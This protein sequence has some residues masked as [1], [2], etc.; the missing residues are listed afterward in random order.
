VKGIWLAPAQSSSINLN[1][2]ALQVHGFHS[3]LAVL[4]AFVKFHLKTPSI[5]NM[6]HRDAGA[7][8]Q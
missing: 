8:R 6:A 7:A 1:P 3:G 2:D 4:K 5:Y